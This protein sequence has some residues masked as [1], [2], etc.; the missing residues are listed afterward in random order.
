MI[1]LVLAA[2]AGSGCTSQQSSAPVQVTNLATIVAPTP[3]PAASATS[4]PTTPLQRIIVTNADA[5]ELLLA[6]GAGDQIVGISD[7]VKTHPV[8]GPRFSGVKSIGSW[9]APDVET[10]ISLH[11]DG[12]ISYSSY[13]PKNVDKITSVGIPLLLID[14][15]KIDTLAS[16]TRKLANLTGREAEAEKYLAFKEQY[17]TLVQ[18]RI[19]NL[20]SVE[21]PR[22]YF[23]SYSD[24]SALTGGSGGDLLTTMAGG[25]NIAGLLPTSSPKVN[26]EWVYAENPEVIVKVAASGKNESEL[27]NIRDTI[28]GR[29]GIANTAAVR[30]GQV[31]VM[32]NSV[33][34]GPRSTVG[35]VYVAKILHPAEFED[36]HPSAILDEYAG[37]FVPGANVTPVFSPVLT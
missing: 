8:L 24:Y 20:T 15:Y 35:L 3:V 12:V 37:R 36:I 21:T 2:C 29:T 1:V 23:E 17:E 25:S 26:A 11:P 30:N 34:Y 18:S 7:T 27:R 19:A 14:C 28:A 22:V 5:A 33:T 16:D 13:M 6:I 31:Y 32:S 4:L 9:Q 10:I